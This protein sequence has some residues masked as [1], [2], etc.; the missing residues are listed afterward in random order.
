VKHNEY[1]GVLIETLGL[2][3]RFNNVLRRARI[4]TIEQLINCSIYYLYRV[5]GFGMV[6][7]HRV[8]EAL[9]GL[10]LE[11]KKESMEQAALKYK[12]S[13]YRRWRK[14]KRQ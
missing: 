13:R 5:D 9:A 1:T 12:Q 8:K 11:L 4:T 14:K 10:G 3:R 6:A 2:S 7:A